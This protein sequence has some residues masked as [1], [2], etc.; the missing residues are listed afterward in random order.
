MTIFKNY[1][2]VIVLFA[3]AAGCKDGCNGSEQVQIDKPLP[4]VDPPEFNADSAYAY[5]AKQVE[6]GP[7]VPNTEAHL[8]AAEW[9]EKILRDFADTVIVQAGQVEAY[10]GTKLN[11][12]N[13]I[14]S[15]NPGHPQRIFLSAHWDTRPYAD[16]D[17]DPENHKTP[18]LGAND[19]ASGVGVLIEIARQLKEK[20]VNLGVDIVLFDVEDYGQPENSGVPPKNDT[21]C[22]GSQYWSKKPHV[23]G[24]KARYGINLDM[25]GAKNSTFL[26]E[27]YSKKYAPTLVRRVWQ[28]AAQLGHSTYFL[29]KESNRPL[30]DDHYY[31]NIIAGIP[32]INIIYTNNNSPNLFH[33]TWHTLDDNMDI[34]DKNVL[35]AVGQTVLYTVYQEEAALL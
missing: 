6:F 15:F 3:F 13:I 25:V 12:R 19:G 10:N 31:V 35:K 30:I 23:P 17:K 16:Q 34:I 20:P 32:T 28:N 11:F 27:M 22:L 33:H 8:A 4:P 9:M 5:V 24:Y 18:I 26:I 1:F 29:F 21:Y 7:R 2:L 14:A